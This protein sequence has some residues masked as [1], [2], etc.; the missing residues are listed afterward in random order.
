MVCEFDEVQSIKKQVEDL[1]ETCLGLRKVE[2]LN[3]KMKSA[4]KERIMA[5]FRSGKIDVL[6]ST[7]VVEVGIDVP[8]ATVMMVEGADRFGLAQLHQF[9]G[10]VGR[11]SM[12]SYC[13]LFTTALSSGDVAG[14]L[15]AF[16]RTDDG[17]E[18]S[19]IDLKLRGLGKMFG[20]EQSGFGDFNPEWLNNENRL[21]KIKAL[22]ERTVS[23]IDKF[24]V[25]KRKLSDE[26]QIAHLE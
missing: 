11:N 20:L 24:E 16:V 7:S 6:V 4:E 1:K 13:F 2:S 8:N 12:Q 17:F 5:D 18:L 25:F 21:K 15:K 19:K 9:R 26:I 23:E 14:R 3:G 22:A 10:R